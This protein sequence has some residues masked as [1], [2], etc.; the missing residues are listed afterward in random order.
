MT[1]IDLS[2]KTR[3]VLGMPKLTRH[4][5]LLTLG[6]T[7]SCVVAS[8]SVTML[9]YELNGGISRLDTLIV[10]TMIPFTLGPICTLIGVRGRQKIQEMA[11]ENERLANTDA[12][13]GLANRRAFFTQIATPPRD[14]DGGAE[15]VAFILCDIDSFKSFND[16]HGHDVGDHVL[17]HVAHL[18]Q[19]SLPSNA[20]IARLGGEEFVVR[21]ADADR[22]DLDSLAATLIAK[23]AETPLRYENKRFKV[24]MSV[25]L[26]I[27]TADADP[28]RALRHADR[29]MYSAKANGRNQFVRAA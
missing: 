8:G 23:V 18:I 9:W 26:H 25:G 17:K 7:L 5:V 11:L 4:A 29:A 13:T 15:T 2:L 6:I 24:T 28:D 19:S 14:Q 16:L 20:A 12:L 21:V 1:D 27:T 10:S 3:K 22:L